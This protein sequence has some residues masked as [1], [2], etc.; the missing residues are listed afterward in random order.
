MFDSLEQGCGEIKYKYIG[1]SGV[2]ILT[3]ISDPSRFY[4]GSSN[5][6]SRRMVEYNKLTRGLINPHSSGE[7]EITKTTSSKWGLEFIYITPQCKPVSRPLCVLQPL[8]PQWIAGFTSGGGY[9]GIKLLSSNTIKT[10]KQV[11]FIFQLTQHT[12][13]DFLMKSFMEYFECGIYYSSNRAYYG[14]FFVI[15]LTDL[16]NKIVPFFLKH[17]ILGEKSKDFNDWCKAIELMKTKEHLTEQGLAKILEI[18]N[19][20]NNKKY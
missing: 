17:K 19:T 1:I 18:R 10:G 13:D 20:M 5:N 4:I 16:I 6:L 9:F 15:K 2:Y 3:N 14:E 12:R 8:W 7:L 11:R